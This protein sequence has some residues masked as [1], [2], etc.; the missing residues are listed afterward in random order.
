MLPTGFEPVFQP[1]KGYVLT[2]RRRERNQS[3]IQSLD[4]WNILFCRSLVRGPL[5]NKLLEKNLLIP[6]EEQPLRN[7][8]LENTLINDLHHYVREYP[9]HFMR[10]KF[11]LGVRVKSSRRGYSRVNSSRRGKRVEYSLRIKKSRRRGARTPN[12][13]F[14]DR[15]FTIETILPC[16]SLRWFE[17]RTSPLSRVRSTDW[18]TGSCS[19]KKESVSM[20]ENFSRRFYA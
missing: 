8:L 6:W 2:P 13:G 10:R 20:I 11:S 1:R 7:K 17:Q 4:Y 18:A 14:G 9:P 15:H 3:F 16:M 5:R 12:A 19:K